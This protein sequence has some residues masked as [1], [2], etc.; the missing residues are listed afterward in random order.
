M[1]EVVQNTQQ[2]FWRPPSPLAGDEIIVR[3]AV[4][5]MAETCP[6]CSS[7]FL[8]GSRFCH[9]CGERRREA[10]SSTARADAAVIARVWEE[11]VARTYSVGARLASQKTWSDLWGRIQF[12]AW[13]RYLHFHE[14]QSRIGLSTASLIAFMIGLGCVA[15]ALVVGLLTAK[16]FVDWQAIQFYRAE[17]LLAATAAFVAGILLK[18]PSG[19]DGE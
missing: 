4:P 13:L 16:T 3:Q 17:W 18:K 9:T 1:S 8:L 14:I 15:G 11:G 7:E 10:I 2:E 12:P 6:R 19:G 5:A